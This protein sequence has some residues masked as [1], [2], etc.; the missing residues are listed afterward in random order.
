M[1]EPISS[2]DDVLTAELH[3]LRLRREKVLGTVPT[4]AAGGTAQQQALA[5]RAFG[6]GIS[7]GGIRSATLNLGIL[8]GLARRGLLP[9]VDYLSTVSG[10]GYI[11]MP[12]ARKGQDPG[13]ERGVGGDIRA[14]GGREMLDQGRGVAL[15]DDVPVV[16]QSSQ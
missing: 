7:G 2:F 5:F 4:P 13:A 3:E 15:N 11:D 6:M 8:Q 1:A 10:G 14:P 12:A 9:Y 16:T